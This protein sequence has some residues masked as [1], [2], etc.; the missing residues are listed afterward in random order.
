MGYFP[1]KVPGHTGDARKPRRAF[2]KV[3]SIFYCDRPIPSFIKSDKLPFRREPTIRELILRTLVVLTM[4]API[5]SL[6]YYIV[7]SFVIQFENKARADYGHWR[8]ELNKAYTA[9]CNSAYVN[10]RNNDL[11]RALEEATLAQNIFPTRAR[12]NMA[13][14]QITNNYCKRYG[15]LCDVA[16]SY[17]D[18]FN[19]YYCLEKKWYE[20]QPLAFIDS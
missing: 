2:E 19:E 9:L 17:L 12:A 10:F 8:S 3:R 5:G 1:I 20:S 15:E 18:Y 7:D 14:Y 4:L 6:A 13:I 11:D 16:A